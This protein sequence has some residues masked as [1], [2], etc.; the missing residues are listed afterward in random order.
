MTAGPWSRPKEASSKGEKAKDNAREE[1]ASEQLREGRPHPSDQSAASQHADCG[2]GPV[3]HRVDREGRPAV[4][5]GRWHCA[6][7]SVMCRYPER[8]RQATDCPQEPNV[9]DRVGEWQQGG[10]AAK[11]EGGQ[12]GCGPGW[13]PHDDKGGQE[14]TRLSTSS[15]S[16]PYLQR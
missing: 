6:E 1:Q 4:R 12:D 14:A 2:A 5:T 15:R 8:H 13:Q 7:E 11:A 16:R 3:T 9:G 10:G